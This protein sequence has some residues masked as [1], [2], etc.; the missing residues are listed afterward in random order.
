MSL[1]R[2]IGRGNQIPWHLPADFRWFRQ[3]TVGQTVV[4]GRRTFESIGHPLPL[5]T[6]LVLS[7]SRFEHPGTRWV[8]N[9]DDIDPEAETGEVFICG[10]AD[11]YRQALPRCSDLYLTVVRREVEGDV[12]FP[13]FEAGFLPPETV[14]Q[15]P[16][17]DILHYRNRLVA[18]FSDAS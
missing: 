12:F 15:N 1:N 14:M 8:A 10:G 16:D 18:G 2:V 11:V 13:E 3:K 7:R 17:F 6:T 4:M 9:L 5:R